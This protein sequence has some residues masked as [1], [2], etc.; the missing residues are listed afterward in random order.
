VS[1]IEASERAGLETSQGTE[2]RPLTDTERAL[3]QRLLSDPFSFPIVFKT[4]LI[5]FLEGS[6]MLLPRSSVQGLSSLLGS[7]GGQ[8][9]LG[10][11]PA[12]M[13]FP[14]GGAAAPVGALLCNGAPYSRAG[15]KRLFDAIGS[16]YGA[17]DGSSTF[18]VPDLRRRLPF[19]GGTGVPQGDNEGRAETDRHVAHH[20]YLAQT[21]TD[22]GTHNHGVHVDGSTDGVGDHTHAPETQS[23]ALTAGTLAALG[24]GGSNRMIVSTNSIQTSGAGGHSHSV[25]ADGGTS[26]DGAHNHFVEGD[27]SGGFDQDQPSFLV[28]G[29]IINY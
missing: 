20:H 7:G 9:V 1:V 23:W 12:G 3:L 13:I 8:G 10:L 14:Y 28:V 27:T 4:W 6:D 16:Q 19:G 5:S 2:Q 21:S 29:F 22:D 18:N 25:S 26:D 15:Y 24:S 11:L 17:G